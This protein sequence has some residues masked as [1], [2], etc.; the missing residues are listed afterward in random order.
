VSY[1]LAVVVPT[2]TRCNALNQCM[3]HS[4]KRHRRAVRSILSFTTFRKAEESGF[5]K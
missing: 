2:Y 3:E 5:L 4:R 1:P